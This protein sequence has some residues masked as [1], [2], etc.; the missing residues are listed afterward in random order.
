MILS[1]HPC[2]SAEVQI[3]LGARQLGPE[4]NSLIRKAK[5]IILPQG[6]SREL[7]EAC[8]KSEALTFPN[9]EIR[10]NYPGKLGQ[11]LLF[12][13]LD[14]PHPETIGWGSVREF[15][16]SISGWELLPLAPPFLIKGTASHEGEGVY[17]IE[18]E[19]S[20]GWALDHLRKMEETGLFGFVTQAYV[21]SGGNTLRV[22]IIGNKIISYWKRPKSPD[23]SITTISRGAL[24]DHDWRP[25]LQEKGKKE[26]LAFSRKTGLNLAALDLVF[27]LSEGDPSPLFLEVNFFFARRGLGG[28]EAYY[29]LLHEAIRDWLSDSGLN[30]ESVKLA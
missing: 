2:F 8:S 10:F 19:A 23:E 3:I 9:Y 15:R 26:A 13:E 29:R 27:S 18:D 16:E 28:S 30:P 11:A 17:V 7:Y 21:H 22:V 14:V 4:E 20:L 12:Q 6:L 1:F 5:A 25:D 24:I